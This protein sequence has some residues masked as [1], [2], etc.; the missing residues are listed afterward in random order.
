M[1]DTRETGRV[2]GYATKTERSDREHVGHDEP[3]AADPSYVI[4]KTKFE[5][6]P[7]YP[8]VPPYKNQPLWKGVPVAPTVTI[9]ATGNAAVKLSWDIRPYM[10]RVKAKINAYELYV[11]K[12]TD[13]APDTSMWILIGTINALTLPMRC[14]VAFL[15]KGFTYH[16]ALRAVDVH[17]RRAPFTVV[18]TAV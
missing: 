9:S 7:T 3:A 16:F 13:L 11:C 10:L 6:P 4:V 14:T 8:R 1:M 2:D 15:A 12:E 5:Y 18:K 17:G